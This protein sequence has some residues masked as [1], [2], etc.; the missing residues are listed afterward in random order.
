[1]SSAR[2]ILGENLT[3][4]MSQRPELGTPAA[5]EVATAKIN[6]KV[7]RSTIDRAKNGAA[8][9]TVENIE[10]VAQ[11]F[12][13]HAWELLKPIKGDSGAT[14]NLL[15]LR[16]DENAQ[17]LLPTLQAAELEGL[18][19]VEL[20]ALEETIRARVAELQELAKARASFVRRQ[21]NAKA[22]GV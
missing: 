12:G 14:S 4:L 5:V 2:V 6:S 17:C 20:A 7:G 16:A 11:V 21:Q 8:N 3:H 22:G 13:K 18:G 9:M 19:E 15:V 10:A 1:M